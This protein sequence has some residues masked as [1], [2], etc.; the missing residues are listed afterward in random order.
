MN[1]TTF[2]TGETAASLKETYNPEGSSMRKVQIRMLEMLMYIDGVCKQLGISYRID[3]GTVLGAV[4]HGG[5]IPWDDDID[6]VLNRHDWNRLCDY[7]KSNPHPQFVLQTH[8]TDPGYYQ[9][10]AK[11]RDL[12]SEYV[13]S[14]VAYSRNKYKGAQLDIFCFDNYGFRTLHT[15]AKS[16]EWINVH[17]FIKNHP[18]IANL[19]FFIS[20]QIVCPFFRMISKPFGKGR[21]YMHAYG[22]PWPLKFPTELLLPH[23]TIVFEGYEVQGPADPVG[24]CKLIYGKNYYQLPPKENRRTH[25]LDVRVWE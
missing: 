11:L 17:F 13:Q 14:E 16:F 25:S 12:K 22:A 21:F 3:G 7:L 19:V 24:L 8:D 23:K 6:L 9:S 15:I 1:I 20:Q 18:R 2:N 10:W 4:R 5:F